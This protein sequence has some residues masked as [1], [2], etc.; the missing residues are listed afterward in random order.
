[1]WLLA[2]PTTTSCESDTPPQHRMILQQWGMAE[3][4]SAATKP[5]PLFIRYFSPKLTSWVGTALYE[6]S[7]G[8][9][10]FTICFLTGP[11]SSESL[12]PTT[13]STS[14]SSSTTTTEE[15]RPIKTEP[16]LSS[17]YGHP[18]P[19]SQVE[20]GDAGSRTKMGTRMVACSK[21]HA[22]A[23]ICSSTANPLTCYYNS[24][25]TP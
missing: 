19:I 24:T 15:M 3:C 1:M 16:G 6:R 25:S 7:L 8:R 2:L 4:P 23:A 14:S 11:S 12:T 18:S 9:A 22:Q 5:F 21:Y 20:R 10:C 13:S 17:H